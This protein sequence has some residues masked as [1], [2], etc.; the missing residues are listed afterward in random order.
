[1]AIVWACVCAIHMQGPSNGGPVG[2]ALGSELLSHR[3][4][5]TH[6]I[7]H[8]EGLRSEAV[9]ESTPMGGWDSASAS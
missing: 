6:E 5:H 1:M 7:T 4:P 3:C 2:V 9:Y 8:W